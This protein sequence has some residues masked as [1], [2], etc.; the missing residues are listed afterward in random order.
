MYNIKLL[1]SWIAYDSPSSSFVYPF[2]VKDQ[3][4]FISYHQYLLSTHNSI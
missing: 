1:G 2:R 3:G 4:Q